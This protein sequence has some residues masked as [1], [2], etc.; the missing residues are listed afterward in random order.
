MADERRVELE[1]GASVTARRYQRQGRRPWPRWS[2]PMAPGPASRA[3]SWWGSPAALAARGLDVVTFNFPFTE[4]GK[5]LPDPQPVLE[6]CYRAVLAHVAADPAGRHAA[7]CSSAASRWAAGWPRMWRRPATSATPTPTRGGIVCAG[8]CSSAIRCTRPASRSRCACRT[9]P[10]S[11]T[12][13]S[14][15]RARRTPSARRP[16]CACS[17]TCCPPRREIYVVEQGNHSLEVPKRSGMSQAAVFAAAQDRIAAWISERVAARQTWSVD[18]RRR[19]REARRVGQRR[20]DRTAARR[21]RRPAR[22][23]ASSPRAASS[24]RTPS[25]ARRRP[26]A[27]VA[28]VQTMSTAG[29]RSSTPMPARVEREH[30]GHEECRQ[31]VLPRQHHRLERIAAGER[32]GRKRRERRRAGSPR[33]ARRSRR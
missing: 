3:S 1:R 28:D 8:S 27:A 6:A 9:C 10:T 33:T 5:K 7:R 13:C 21:R 11:P 31:R 20:R 22:A 23:R 17:S 32:R 16:N 18:G 26:S 15:C 30:E 2:S 24:R 14:S 29:P 12:R 4:R 25:P 19:D